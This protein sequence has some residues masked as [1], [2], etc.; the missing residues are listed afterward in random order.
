VDPPGAVP[1]TVPLADADRIGP[2]IVGG[3][4]ANLAR[5]V[6][7][8]VHVPV[9]FCIT[10]A[11]YDRFVAWHGLDAVIRRELDRKPLDSM[12]WEE[13]WD[14][15]LR[16]RSAFLRC[17][18]PE[19][20]GAAVRSA[21][22]RLPGTG[23]VAVR[24]SAPGE[25]TVGCSFAG[26]HDSVTDV[27]DAPG[28][29]DALRLVWASL[30]SDAA[31]LYRRELGLDAARSG[32]A[33]LVQRMAT[34]DRSGVAFGR[35]PRHPAATHQVIEAVAGPCA[36]LVDGRIDPDRWIL[37]RTTGAAISWRSGERPPGAAS[38]PLLE[39]DDLWALHHALRAFERD[40]GWP[41]DVEWT[42]RGAGLTI[43]QVRPITTSPS[44][45]G[46]D[47]RA[48]YLSL[49][50]KPTQ[51]R[52]LR[53]HIVRDVIPALETA[54]AA[55]AAEDLACMADAELADALVARA[56]ALAR[57][58]QVYHDELIPFAHGVR[59]LGTYYTDAVRPEDPYEFVGL[60]AHEPLLA[61]QRNRALADLAARLRAD[62]DLSAAAVAAQ[63][64]AA[65][66]RLSWDD[67]TA[68]L[69]ETPGG[70]QFA[71]ALADVAARYCD[72]TYASERAIDHAEQLLAVVIA[73]MDRSLPSVPPSRDDPRVRLEARLF[74]AVGP[75]REREAREVLAT[76]RL[77]WRLR[78]DD[79]VLIGRIES[80]VLRAV[81]EADRRLR[82]A[83]RARG[84]APTERDIHGLASSLR[85]P[86][87]PPLQIA[88]GPPPSRPV[89]RDPLE[90]SRQLVG[91]PAAPGVATGRA[92]HIRDGTDLSR[93]R[94]GHVLVC[95]AIEPTMT[96][97]LPLAAAVI[98]RRGGMLIHGAII[99]RELG[100]PCVNG[101]PDA[102]ARLPAG[103]L[104]SVDGY[105][106]IV[107]V[108]APDFDLE[109]AGAPSAP[110][111]PTA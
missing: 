69:A 90:T 100:I 54:G 101:I 110:A 71:A 79:N 62:S 94:A 7:S 15:A 104:V 22:A 80:Q 28:V 35:D 42:G 52:R 68:R 72:T 10:T 58:R 65:A 51:L 50:P 41:P 83:G 81:Q 63:S 64:E 95:D 85:D 106:G 97:V 47:P 92:Y 6:R 19:D 109:L 89:F 75:D 84:A 76:A 93:I 27:V 73:L 66:G 1:L 74:A 67:L 32:M 3:K 78:D 29:L 40:C 18:I 98:E 2:R 96:H 33:V 16:I 111:T 24:S 87:A 91:Q 46:S 39:A 17:P 4:A 49:R 53:D 86:G 31:L 43:L 59:Q 20:I 103:A 88:A 23:P 82:A 11:T 102:L 21:L 99:A 9:G 34:A 5:L 60:L 12:R 14:A 44:D 25:D 36:A 45:E 77:S 55:L 61:L 13:L 107:T 30:W 48:W 108:G 37:D 38:E 56:D 70:A 57:W 8:G 26:L 105:L